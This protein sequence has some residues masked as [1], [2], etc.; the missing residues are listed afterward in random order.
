MTKKKQTKPTNAQAKPTSVDIEAIEK[1]LPPKKKRSHNVIIKLRGVKK[2]FKVGGRRVPVLKGIDLTFYSGEFAI[3]YGP[4]G[5]GKSTLLHTTLGL[6]KPSRGKV[7]LRGENLY[8]LGDDERTNYRREKIGMVFQQSNWIKSMSVWENVAYPLNL[9]G[10]QFDQTRSLALEALTEVELDDWADH[11]PTELS[12]GQ[13]QRAALARAL[14][15]EPWIIIADEPT[16]NLDSK[17]GSDLMELL[18]RLNRKK[19]R[20]ILMVTHDM[21]FLPLANRRVAMQDGQIVGDDHD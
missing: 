9:A 7:E 2:S 11:K 17:A 20:M 8:R 15:T 4:S 1:N 13:Q 5:C 6:E 16:G 12:G 19:R 3:V 18:A 14:V 10:H 21:G